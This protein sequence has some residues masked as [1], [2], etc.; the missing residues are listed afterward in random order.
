VLDDSDRVVGDSWTIA[1]YLEVAYP[2]R[3]GFVGSRAAA[4]GLQTVGVLSTP[5][6][7]LPN[8]SLA[9]AALSEGRSTEGIA[10]FDLTR[11]EPCHEPA[12]A[13]F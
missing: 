7:A 11:F 8:S 4:R 5:I 6:S 3:R 12:R 9:S 2:A 1:T 13:L 10:A